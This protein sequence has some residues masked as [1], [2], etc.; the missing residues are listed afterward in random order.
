MSVVHEV[1]HA[2]TAVVETLFAVGKSVVEADSKESF[3]QIFKRQCNSG[4]TY[5]VSLE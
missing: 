4:V 5:F 2:E 1:N 3:A